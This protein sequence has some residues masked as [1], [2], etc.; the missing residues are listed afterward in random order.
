MR[1]NI[2]ESNRRGL[3]RGATVLLAG[4]LLAGCSSGAMR[5]SDGVDGLFT[6][7]TANQRSIIKPAD[8]PFPGESASVDDGYANSGARAAVTPAPL[9]DTGVSRSS[10]EPAPAPVA[11][12]PAPVAQPVQTAAVA[13]APEQRVDNSTTGTVAPAPAAASGE[14]AGWSRAGGT[15]VTIREG[16][17]LYNLSRRYGVPA[18]VLAS[19]NGMEGGAGLK[20]GQKIVIP[21]YVYSRKA[22]V[23]APDSDPNVADA[24]SSRGTKYDVPLDRL[25]TPTRAPEQNVAVLPQAPKLKEAEV[26]ST[27]TSADGATAPA[28]GGKGSYTVQSG[29]TLSG[30]AAKTGVGA[31]A[32]KQANGMKDGFLRIGQKLT[33]PGGS[34]ATVA[35]AKPAKADPVVTGSAGPA[36]KADS[37]EVAG[38]TPP[39]ASGKDIADVETLQA[40][41]PDATGIGRM[42]WPARGRVISDFGSKSGSKPNDGIDIALPEGT[43][44]KAAENGVVIYAGDGLKEFGNTVLVRHEDGLV[45]VYGYASEIKVSRGDKVKRGQDIALSGMSGSAEMPKLHFEVRKNSAP[46]DPTTFLE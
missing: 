18:N 32:I 17:T 10:L 34:G 44:V 7:S 27:K 23:S 11:A 25:P 22:P 14:P 29:D 1:L 4:S 42:R 45:T 9:G 28:S 8:Q 43:P 31:A 20:A 2:L 30:I 16:E 35:A 38:Y 40:K 5:F 12:A 24:K 36:K 39:R 46:V 41:A 26:A 33:I 13:P 15:Q 19:V 6:G 37:A 3:L 21:T